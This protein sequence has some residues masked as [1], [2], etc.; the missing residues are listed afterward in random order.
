[1]D[2]LTTWVII[3]FIGQ[4]FFTMRFAVQW[5]VTEKK[6]ESSIPIQFWYLSIMGSILLFSYALY[7]KD[8]V[9]ILGQ[10]F[11]IIVYSR[12]L[13]FIYK[14]KKHENIKRT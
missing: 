4:L 9:F 2:K 14:N 12:N 11:G 8:P 13:F 6:K 3:G 10:S 5:I 1:M 7:R